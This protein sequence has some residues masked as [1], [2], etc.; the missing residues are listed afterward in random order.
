[1]IGG[2]VAPGFEAVRTAFERCFTELGET[3]A[4][5]GMTD[6]ALAMAEADVTRQMGT[7]D[8]ADALD[9]ALREAIGR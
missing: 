6:P 8:R 1:V 7:H 5:L 4:S 2:T 3:G 9:A